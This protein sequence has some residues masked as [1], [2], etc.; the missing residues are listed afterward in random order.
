MKGK[1]MKKF[2]LLRNEGFDSFEFEGTVIGTNYYQV[3]PL[4]V[5]VGGRKIV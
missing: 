5:F 1:E 2:G 4:S 3:A